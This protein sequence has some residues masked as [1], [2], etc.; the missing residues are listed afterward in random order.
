MRRHE[1][2][3]VL[4]RCSV[5]EKLEMQAKILTPLSEEQTQTPFS[6]ELPLSLTE[7]QTLSP[8]LK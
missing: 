7:D 4:V 8:D 2:S 5:A 1:E 3:S 6:P